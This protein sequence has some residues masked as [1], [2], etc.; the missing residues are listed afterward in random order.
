M[1][2][3]STRR[4]HEQIDPLS[5]HIEINDRQPH[6]IQ[7][8][9]PMVKQVTTAVATTEWDTGD[10]VGLRIGQFRFSHEKRLRFVRNA[11]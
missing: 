7:N 5:H 4:T 10:L 6:S 11:A 1:L 2:A 9:L 3:I 8:R